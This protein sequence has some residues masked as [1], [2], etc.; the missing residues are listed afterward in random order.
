M[1]QHTTVIG[2]RVT[3]TNLDHAA[4]TRATVR[5]RRGSNWATVTATSGQRIGETNRPFDTELVAAMH[6]LAYPTDTH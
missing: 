4:A 2:T 1:M 6:A 3:V 5:R